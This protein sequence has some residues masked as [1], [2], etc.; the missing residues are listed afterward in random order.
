[1]HTLAKELVNSR[2]DVLVAS[3]SAATVALR[4]LTRTIPIVFSE[5]SD[6]VSQGIV[7]SM[8]RPGGNATGFTAFQ[9]TMASKWLELLKEMVPD[10]RRVAVM[11]NPDTAGLAGTSYL[12]S[13]EAD[14]A[15]FSVRSS[16]APVHNTGDIESAINSFAREPNGGLIV[17]PDPFIVSHRKQIIEL[18]ARYRLPT[19]Y[20]LSYFAADGGLLSYGV[21]RN[22]LFRLAG[23]YVDRILRGANPANLPV[24]NSTKFE[25]VINLKTAKMLGLKIPSSLLAR[26]DEVIE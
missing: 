11:F 23:L 6:P 10:L 14:A 25:L 17:P 7:E 19:I 2:P 16:G 12:R 5:T 15:L 21:N 13:V 3:G 20:T 9:P 22:E 1:M 18:T 24:Q 4:Q 26:A 8:A